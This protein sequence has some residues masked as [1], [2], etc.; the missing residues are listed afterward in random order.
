MD[1]ITYALARQVASLSGANGA[2]I[3]GMEIV[4]GNLIVKMSDGTRI[5]AGKVPTTDSGVITQI[6]TVQNDVKQL[7]NSVVTQ[8]QLNGQDVMVKNNTLNLPLAS[9]AVIGL[10]KGTD[11]NSENSINKIS[12][13][14]DG[15]MEVN[16]L[17]TD[18]L[19]AGHEILIFNGNYEDYFN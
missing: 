9:G 7:Q 13:K 2:K 4:N 15:T 17:S 6:N 8:V 1:L 12:V 19:V 16:S 14:N 11:P 3:S 18:K 5:D 10:V